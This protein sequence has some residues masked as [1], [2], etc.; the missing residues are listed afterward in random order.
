MTYLLRLVDKGD[1]TTAVYRYTDRAAAVK[2][3]N[4]EAYELA[5]QEG[6]TIA[7]HW[8]TECDTA[9]G[10]FDR[11]TDEISVREAPMPNEFDQWETVCP[12]CAAEDELYV[13]EATINGEEHCPLNDQ[14]CADGFTFD[15]YNVDDSGGNHTEDEVVYCRACARKFT[16]DVLRLVDDASVCE[17]GHTAESHRSDY[18]LSMCFWGSG[19]GNNCSCDRFA[20]A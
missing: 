2:Q 8:H 5:F 3:A 12:S 18:G 11:D 15:A 7:E 17:C 19:I 9:T 14:L 13:I 16:L 10:R 4:A 1:G 20:E 6:R